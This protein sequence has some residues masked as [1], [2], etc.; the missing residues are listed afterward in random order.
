M[1]ILCLVSWV[2]QGRWLWDYIPGNCDTVDFVYIRHPQDRFPG[3][4]KLLGYY[5]KFWW[6]G[7]KALPRLRHY[8][9]IVTWE[10]NTG[11]PLAF[12]R[13][14]LGCTS[15]PMVILNFVLKGR[16]I[17]DMLWLVRYALRSVDLIACVSVK[18]VEYYSQKL[19]LPTDRFVQ[20]PTTHPDYHQDRVTEIYTGDYILAAGRSHRDYRTFVEAVRDLPIKAV[21]NARP[22]NVAGLA[23]PPNVTMNPFLPFHEFLTLVRGA[24]FVV[25]P[26]YAARHASGETFMLEAMAARKAVIATET[27]STV[28][29]IEPGIN[30]LLVPPGDA[31][32]M[33]QA[34]QYLLD[35]PEQTQQM[36]LAARQMYETRW[37][38]PVIARQ[39]DAILTRLVS[40]ASGR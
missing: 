34:I 28:E 21:I 27:Y 10:G 30:G 13:T 37:S 3:Y 6:L 23:V 18:E 9:V 22:F 25:L 39:V 2:P 12:L 20:L 4:G 26:L 15:P 31:T 16:P 35:H 17:L 8:D 11:L 33:R 24:R 1:K 29:F 7:L 19:D 36:G 38:F 14:L 5:Q 40:E 32:A